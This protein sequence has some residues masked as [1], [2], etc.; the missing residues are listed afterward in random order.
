MP[1]PSQ[2]S[3]AAESAPRSDDERFVVALVLSYY[4]RDPERARARLL[5]L[6]GEALAPQA[7]AAPAPAPTDDDDALWQRT[8]SG[9]APLKRKR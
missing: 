7:Q 6:L 2:L 5:D 3:A 1:R 9:V 4:R 8:R